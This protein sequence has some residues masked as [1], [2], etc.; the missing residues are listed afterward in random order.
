[1]LVAAALL[2]TGV[3][4]TLHAPAI[5]SFDGSRVAAMSGVQGDCIVPCENGDEGRTAGHQS[6]CTFD[7]AAPAILDTEP[8]AVSTF[9][10]AC[11]AATVVSLHSEQRALETP[12]PIL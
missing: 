8:L 4:S 5:A 7:C 11:D 10:A 3:A 6:C 1:M 2:S 9:V 12:P